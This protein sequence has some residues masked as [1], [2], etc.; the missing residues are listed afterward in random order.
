M[1][2]SYKT[3]Q[4]EFW[5]GNFGDDYINRNEGKELLASNLNFF[6]KALQSTEKIDSVVEFGANIGMNLRALKL[7][8]PNQSQHAVE[9]NQ[10]AAQELASFVDEDNI[11]VGSIFDYKPADK[12]SLSLIKG[13]LIHIAPEMLPSVYNVLYR[14]S[15]KYILVCEYYN[16]SP[17]SIEYRGHNDRLFKRDFC[18]DMLD[19]FSDLTLVDYGFAYKRD[20]FPQDDITWFLMKK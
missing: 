10:T 3:E 1:K 18:G 11:F 14:S 7:L 20:A 4:E 9:I 17:V 15:D 8:Y 16:P 13:V 2:M 5:A 6:T 19:R 12:V